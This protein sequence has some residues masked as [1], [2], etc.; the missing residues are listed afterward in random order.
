MKIK[1][2]TGDIT[3]VTEYGVFEIGSSEDGL[4]ICPENRHDN[5]LSINSL[6]GAKESWSKSNI[7][8]IKIEK[9]KKKK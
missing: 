6:H 4:V 1:L 7:I 3:I 8:W 2:D 9:E 5:V